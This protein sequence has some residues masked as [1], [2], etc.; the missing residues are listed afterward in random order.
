M[1][2]KP[3]FVSPHNKTIDVSLPFVSFDMT[4]YGDNL[5]LVKY[6]F[7]QDDKNIKNGRTP[8]NYYN[9]DRF[10]IST[11]TADF[12]NGNN[13]TYE[14]ELYQ[15]DILDNLILNGTVQNP[16]FITG[17]VV[18]FPTSYSAQFV[19]VHAPNAD[20]L[21]ISIGNY[22]HIND[23]VKR[24]TAYDSTS[25]MVTLSSK[26]TTPAVVDNDFVI[27]QWR[28]E[29]EIQTTDNSHFYIKPNIDRLIIDSDKEMGLKINN[30]TIK[31][32]SYNKKTGYVT[33][34]QDFSTDITPE[35]RYQLY[36]NYIVSQRYF[37]TAE[38]TPTLSPT[39]TESTTST[40]I[41][42]LNSTITPDN[43]RILKYTWDTYKVVN[44]KNVLV[45]TSGDIY[46]RNF[47]YKTGF[48]F[49]NQTYFST[50]SVTLQNSN[51]IKANTANFTVS[52]PSGI[53]CITDI[54]DSYDR[55]FNSIRLDWDIEESS[56]S[57]MYIEVFR[58]DVVTGK[59]ERLGVGWY[60]ETG[61][62]KTYIDYTSASTKRYKYRLQPTKFFNSELVGKMVSYEPIV[63]YSFPKWSVAFIDSSGNCSKER[64]WIFEINP[65]ISEITQHIGHSILVSTENP[66][67]QMAKSNKNY[68][69]VPIT[70]ELSKIQ[71]GGNSLRFIDDIYLVERWRNEIATG[72]KA[73]IKSPKGDVFKGVITEDS[74]I[75]Y[76]QTEKLE[77][78]ISFNI[79]QIDNDKDVTVSFI[80]DY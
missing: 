10:G 12:Q 9:G 2:S 15:G 68:L 66:S 46:S 42:V 31:I 40:G 76:A 67:V 13:Y 59:Q 6:K 48:L 78:T 35:T 69:S 65:Q 61:K 72:D 37:F 79:T 57:P 54:R 25:G 30:Q 22:M 33:M 28:N 27:S 21:S 62:G 70:C 23:E 8:C 77:T 26:L 58:E 43:A 36:S 34:L 24:I 73:V 71:C 47:E 5:K 53:D 38:V 20:P 7:Y 56:P 60:P 1:L 55:D 32:T 63:S 16:P 39:A 14:I 80:D 17:K 44:S 75:K 49:P 3:A 50:L 19:P 29:S 45:D 18:S 41:Y 11:S 4:F 51:T 74:N 64:T 52:T